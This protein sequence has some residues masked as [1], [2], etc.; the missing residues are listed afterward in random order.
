MH[1]YDDD[2]YT[3]RH[4]DISHST[5]SELAEHHLE[6]SLKLL[7]RNLEEAKEVCHVRNGDEVRFH[8]H[9]DFPFLGNFHKTLPHNEFGEVDPDAFQFLVT[10]CI[11]DADFDSCEIV[12]GQGQLANPLG[13]YYVS[14]QGAPSWGT[15][16]APPPSITSREMA[17]Q[18]PRWLGWPSYAI[19]PL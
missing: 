5:I 13:G 4:C 17:C 9:S 19:F 6:L 16:V 12:P 8:E 2:D 3:E 1:K 15:T 7:E 18:S 11:A 10:D 14:A